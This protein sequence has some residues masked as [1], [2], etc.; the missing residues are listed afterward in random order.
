MTDLRL[1]IVEDDA[2]QARLLADELEAFGHRATVVAD[3][4]A[5]L[6]EIGRDAFDAMV[7]DRMLPVMDGV[8]VVQHVRAAGIGIP[9]LMLTAL[10]QTFE[11]V[12]GLGAGADDYVVK[13][14]ESA[15]LNARL[16]ALVRARRWKADPV[17]TIEVGDIRISPIKFRAWRDG[18]DLTLPRTEFLLLLELARNAGAVLTRPMLIERVWKYDFEPTTNIVD[19]YVRRLRIKLM[20]FGHDDPIVTARGTGYMLRAD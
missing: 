17:D 20:Q 1:L 11:K 2:Q 4:Q 12:E 9:T 5:A 15:E 18:K 6:E 19:V 10:G 8:T 13:P 3:G 7:L 16:Q 14:V